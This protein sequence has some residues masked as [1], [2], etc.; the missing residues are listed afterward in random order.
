MS[1]VEI[2]LSI[3]VYNAEKFIH[4]SL[5]S[6]LNQ[7]FNNY[8]ILIIDNNSTDNT[9]KL[10]NDIKQESDINNKIRIIK[11]EKNRGLGAS[12]NTAIENAKGKYLFFMDSDDSI[13]PFT[14]SLLYNNLIK[15]NAEIAIGSLLYEDENGN[16]LLKLKCNN[17]Y[18][19]C[20]YAILEDMKSFYWMTWNKLYNVDFLKKNNIHCIPHHLHE[21]L[22]FTFQVAAF[23][24]KVIFLN[25]ETYHYLNNTNSICNQNKKNISDNNIIEHIEIL[26]QEYKTIRENNIFNYT[27][28]HNIFIRLFVDTSYLVYKSKSKHKKDFF[29]RL[30][31][32]RPNIIYKNIDFRGLIFLIFMKIFSLKIAVYTDYHIITKFIKNARKIKNYFLP[33]KFTH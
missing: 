13:E 27:K 26:E 6:A 32:I 17:V 12:K 10:I 28:I 29:N 7:D 30:N 9:I 8:E 18:K 25:Q 4:K 31:R 22:W 3:P 20:K 33:Y 5:L 2:T 14:L 23:A 15:Y 24:S 19:E 21:D 16:T 11:H 1:M